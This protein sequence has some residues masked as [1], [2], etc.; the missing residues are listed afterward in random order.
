[1]PRIAADSENIRAAH[2]L[3]P[4]PRPWPQSLNCSSVGGL[5]GDKGISGY[6]AS[7]HGVIGVT[8]TAALEYAAKGI[9]VDALC[10]GTIDTAIARS[11]VEGDE[12]RV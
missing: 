12:K 4:T 5:T 6:A 2:T 10:P 7:K 1:M 8:R 11:V 9:R 3:G